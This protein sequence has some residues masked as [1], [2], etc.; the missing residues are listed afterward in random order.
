MKQGVFIYTMRK[1][2]K[3][4]KNY[5]P[6]LSMMIFIFIGGVLAV[7]TFSDYTYILLVIAIFVLFGMYSIIIRAQSNKSHKKTLLMLDFVEQFVLALSIHKTVINALNSVYEISDKKIRGELDS[8]TDG[9]GFAKLEY[10]DSYFNSPLYQA[11]LDIVSTY[12]L[13]GGN[14]ISS[15]SILLKEIAEERSFLIRIK[16]LNIVKFIELTIAWLFVYLI[17]VMLR[18]AISD[19]YIN[20]LA[21]T[22]FAQGILLFFVVALI[23]IVLSLNIAKKSYE[24]SKDRPNSKRVLEVKE[25]IATFSIFRMGLNGNTNIYRALEKT[26]HNTRGALT[27]ELLNLSASIKSNLTVTPFLELAARFREPLIKHILI[28]IYQLMIN[29]G[30]TNVLFEFNYLFD[31][32]N[33]L[34]SEKKYH[35]INKKHENLGQMPLLGTGLLVILIMAGVISILGSFLYV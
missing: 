16:R 20:L 21:N 31:R 30:D 12:L 35:D 4:P 32:L 14:I 19:M 13:E 23:S 17:I 25:F 15:S 22:F 9:E 24:Q 29:G 2:V 11:F 6:L 26:A 5:Q 1:K 28:N 34:N 7:V 10:L 8:F 33:E 27:Q 18:F 3:S